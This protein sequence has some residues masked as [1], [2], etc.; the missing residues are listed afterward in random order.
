MSSDLPYTEDE[1]DD[2]LEVYYRGPK[3]HLQRFA[4]GSTSFT[5][6]L[7]ESQWKSGKQFLYNGRFGL[8]AHFESAGYSV[9]INYKRNK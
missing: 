2:A 3:V 8:K 5:P 7:D 4:P 1:A 6:S 9:R